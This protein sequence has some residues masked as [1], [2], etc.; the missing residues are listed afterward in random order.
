MVIAVVI[1][2]AVTTANPI[3]N[4]IASRITITI[5]FIAFGI[6]NANPKIIVIA[7]IFVNSNFIVVTSIIVNSNFIV[8][9]SIIVNS[10]ATTQEDE[11]VCDNE[12][13]GI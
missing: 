10:N 6:T 1:Y 9:T 4:I 12:F 2:N 7:S 5:S 11:E 8:V 3:A 13:T